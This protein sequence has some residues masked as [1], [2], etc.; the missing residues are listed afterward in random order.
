MKVIYTIIQQYDKTIKQNTRCIFYVLLS[1]LNIR[2]QQIIK[3]D[4]SWDGMP[5]EAQTLRPHERGIY[6]YTQGTL[7]QKTNQIHKIYNLRK[8]L[9][10][11]ISVS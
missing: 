4:H 9:V 6:I 8:V 3:Y 10:C 11:F 2:Q 1:L 5:C 7:R